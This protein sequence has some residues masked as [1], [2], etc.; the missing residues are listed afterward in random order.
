[1]SLQQLANIHTCRTTFSNITFA[2][3]EQFLVAGQVANR[4]SRRHKKQLAD[5][6]V[7]SLNY[8]ILHCIWHIQYTRSLYEFIGEP[9]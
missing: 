4:L 3:K 8:E 7:M 6:E 9:Q 1:M 5:N 2:S